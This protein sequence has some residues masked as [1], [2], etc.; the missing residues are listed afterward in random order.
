MKLITGC[1]NCTKGYVKLN[2]HFVSLCHATH[3]FCFVSIVVPFVPLKLYVRID[4]IFLFLFLSFRPGAIS[5]L[6]LS[7]MNLLSSFFTLSRSSSIFFFY[8]FLSQRARDNFLSML[9]LWS[10][11]LFILFFY[12][13]M[14]ESHFIVSR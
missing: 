2:D 6:F 4:F 5:I 7:L 1:I 14:S 13:M 3:V 8:K 11:N 12:T 10:L 9:L